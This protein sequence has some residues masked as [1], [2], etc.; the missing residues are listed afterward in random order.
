MCSIVIS[1]IDTDQVLVT[2]AID[3]ETGPATR[4]A[5]DLY[6]ELAAILH[7]RGM[8][9]LHERVF[10]TLDFYEQF[11]GIR[12]QCLDIEN[13]PFSYIE[14]RPCRGDGLAGIQVHAVQPAPGEDFWIIHDGNRPCGRGWKQRDAT[15]VYL[16]GITGSGQVGGRHD[17]TRNQFEKINRLLA[18]QNLDFGCVVRTWIYLEDILDW[19]DTFN[20]VRTNTFVELGLI[21]GEMEDPGIDGIYLPASTGISGKNPAGAPGL[22]DVLAISGG[23][24]TKVLPGVSQRSAFRYGSAFSRGISV[25]GKGFRQLFVSGTAAIDDRGN[26]L[27][28]GN[29][30]AQIARTIENVQT[31]IAEEGANLN[32]IRCAT[33]FLKRPEDKNIFETVA[34][35]FHMHHL[36]AV[37]VAA[38]ICRPELLFEMDALAVVH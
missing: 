33:V 25:Q 10:G 17:W 35:R 36:P 28:P 32:D 29:V 37:Y 27:H 24:K 6:R 19:Y 34:G 30:E 38:D 23:L 26:S 1:D 11:V 12:S 8:R 22:C 16:A 20:L 7:S 21:P 31:L 5:G 2:A 13:G 9:I 15:Y 18:A 3:D 14:G 4:T